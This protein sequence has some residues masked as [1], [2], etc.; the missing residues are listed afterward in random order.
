MHQ[1]VRDSLEDYLNRRGGRE[2]PREMAAH[3]TDCQPCARELEQ[4]EKQSNLL[5]TLRAEC[6]PTA[7]FMPG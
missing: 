3:L 4:L 7:G 5:R 2:M 1:P 6:E